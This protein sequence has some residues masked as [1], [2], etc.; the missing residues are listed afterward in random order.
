IGAV[1]TNAGE[2][3]ADERGF[4]QAPHVFNF[5]E[6]RHCMARGSDREEP[7]RRPLPWR[8]RNGVYGSCSTQALRP[9]V[10]AYR[11]RC[12][13][14]IVNPGTSTIGKPLPASAQVVVP[15]GSIITPKSDAAYRSPLTSSRTSAVIGKSGRLLLRSTHVA[16]VHP[17]PSGGVQVTSKTWPGVVGVFTL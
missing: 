14:T 2:A 9:C 1:Q 15:D 8:V 5:G 10:A 7:R 16:A 4:E 17:V 12:S 6:F 13:G 11:R 3:S